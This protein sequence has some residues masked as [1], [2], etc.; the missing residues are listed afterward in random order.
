[1]TRV[2][3]PLQLDHLVVGA[4]SL[5]E[6]VDWIADQFAVS[7]PAGGR[8]ETMGTHNHVMRIGDGVYLEVIAIDP[9][10]V[11]PSRPRWFDLDN[12][13][14]GR[15]LRRGPRLLTWVAR[16]PPPRNLED[17]NLS[18]EWGAA[19]SMARGRL[20]WRITVP[21]DGRLPGGG[22]LPT[23][24]QWQCEPP[25]ASMADLGCRLVKVTLRHRADD[26]LRLRLA[27]IGASDL[28]DVAHA[29]ADGARIE[30]EFETRRG[31]VVI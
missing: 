7:I 15:A 11:A 23:L 27:S 18:A 28:V 29:D 16:V 2:N 12:P 13:W 1:M 17:V 26:W 4:R 9:D 19:L 3:A 24:L 31:R 20:R 10:A 25:A 6:G 14:V 5:A 8:H 22:F 21:D 30:A